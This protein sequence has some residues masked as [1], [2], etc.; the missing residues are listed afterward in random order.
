MKVAFDVGPVFQPLT[1]I[2]RYALELARALAARPEIARLYYIDGMS[3]LDRPD[4]RL[5]AGTLTGQPA[6]AAGHTGLPRRLRRLVAATPFAPAAFATYHKLLRLRFMNSAPARDADL[7]H[8]TGYR[9]LPLSVPGV[10][11]VHD[12]SFIRY[13]QFHPAARVRM[14]LDTLPRTLDAAAAIITDATAIREGVITTYG[15]APER[16]HAIALGVAPDFHP[17]TPEEVRPVLARHGLLSTPYLLSVSTLEPR[18]NLVGLVD[19]YSRLPQALRAR[20]PLVL[21]GGKGWLSEKLEKRLA[22]LERAGKVRRL[23]YVPQAD[24]PHVYAGAWAFAYPSFY[25]GF[26][27]PVAE[28][29]ASGIPTLTSNRSSLP[30]VAG[31]AALQINPEDADAL[32][33]GLQQLL[34]DGELRAR[35]TRAGPLQ[36]ARFTWENTA[37][38]TLAVYGAARAG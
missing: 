5:M 33:D 28:A 23:G 12:L 30:E 32:R 13:P 26:G 21:A 25:E 9:P 19:A 37:R 22:P 27:L 18:K 3:C 34:E 8:G 11:T 2:G 4:A 38:H 36:A 14:L 31:E 17:R 20:H 10:I 29:M 7:Y 6:R 1:G 24:L 35:L 15:I 16:V